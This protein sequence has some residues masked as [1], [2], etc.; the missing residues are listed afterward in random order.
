MK[1]YS[2]FGSLGPEGTISKYNLYTNEKHLMNSPFF[3]IT[4][5][6]LSPGDSSKGAKKPPC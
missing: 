5:L 2:A 6:K 4:L 1:K 3:T